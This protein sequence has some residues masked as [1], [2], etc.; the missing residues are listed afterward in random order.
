[1]KAL[2]L[3]A[4]ARL[5]LPLGDEPKPIKVLAPANYFSQE[6]L[7]QKLILKYTFLFYHPCKHL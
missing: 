2:H 4:L 6:I 5:I 3:A 7:L 1:M